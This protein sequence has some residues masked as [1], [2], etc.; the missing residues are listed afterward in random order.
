MISL[1]E[2]ADHREVSEIEYDE[3]IPKEK[4]TTV[5]DIENGAETGKAMQKLK[6]PV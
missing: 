4:K 3:K 2:K 1:E 5:Y 6:L